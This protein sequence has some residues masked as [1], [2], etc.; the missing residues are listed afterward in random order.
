M[1]AFDLD[2]AEAILDSILAEHED[3]KDEAEGFGL[4]LASPSSRTRRAALPKGL[5]P[6]KEAQ[7][8]LADFAKNTEKLRAFVDSMYQ[9]RA[10][11]TP[12]AA[13][14][15][16]LQKKAAKALQ[17]FVDD[18]KKAQAAVEKY[19]DLLTGE[20]FQ[21]AFEAVRH[22][23][24][25]LDLAD[26]VD[27]DFKTN[28]YLN[29]DPAYA[30]GSIL[31]KRGVDQAYEVYV[32]YQA[33]TDV[34][35][36]NILSFKRRKTFQNVVRKEGVT[37]LPKFVRELVDQL[38]ALDKADATGV[39]KTRKTVELTLADPEAVKMALDAAVLKKVGTIYSGPARWNPPITVGGGTASG[40][41]SWSGVG[42]DLKEKAD[43]K[44]II[45][46]MQSLFLLFDR[47]SGSLTVPVGTA[48]WLVDIKKAGEP[49]YTLNY[50][51]VGTAY[52][53]YQN[54]SF[55][56]T[57]EL[58]NWLKANYP[59][60]ASGVKKT[61][62]EWRRI[63]TNRGIKDLT[64]FGRSPTAI[65]DALSNQKVFNR[66]SINYT[67][68]VEAK[69]V[70]KKATV[71]PAVARVLQAHFRR[72][73]GA[74][75]FMVFS[76]GSD[77]KQ[78]FRDAVDESRYERGHGGYSG[79]ISEKHDY[80]IRSNTPM[81]RKDANAFA[82]KDID[83]NDKWGPAFAV[84]VSEERVLKTEPVTVTVEAKND[85]DAIRQG[86]FRIKA[87]GRVPPKATILVENVKVKKT[88]GGPRVST[89]EVT[90]TR[91]Q[92]VLGEIKGWLFYGIASS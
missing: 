28:L 80:T 17:V 40:K 69:Q 24:L 12:F 46:Y 44:G 78:A 65:Q 11:G 64:P 90:G 50:F 15:D 21:E 58:E 4:R 36:A 59:E 66:I 9:V 8:I 63:A 86:T 70:G 26:D 51:P 38:L 56:T 2:R 57:A 29:A 19:E 77:A 3:L 18:Q 20:H 25:D 53:G 43:A 30:M 81:S 88:G 5:M 83:R 23:I 48:N 7:R 47:M 67:A 85:A 33:Q 87:T 49:T 73:A 34:F 84:P 1:P 62:D 91:K 27:V 35:Y 74:S 60:R 79:T 61:L 22:A 76:L 13:D 71:D 39:F 42:Y 14:V 89:Y 52:G 75:D 37:R 55:S 32:G 10:S 31:L 68:S 54:F 16:A 92:A 72:M 45:S 41:M 6:L 82:N